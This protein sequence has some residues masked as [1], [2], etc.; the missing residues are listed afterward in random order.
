MHKHD[1]PS[2]FSASKHGR[3]KTKGWI[4][5]ELDLSGDFEH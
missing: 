4:Q 5:P 3:I 1:D 2:L